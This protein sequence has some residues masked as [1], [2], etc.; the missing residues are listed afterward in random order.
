MSITLFFRPQKVTVVAE[1]EPEAVPHEK[2][3]FIIT[4]NRHQNPRHLKRAKGRRSSDCEQGTFGFICVG[5][6]LDNDWQIAFRVIGYSQIPSVFF[7][8]LKLDFLNPYNYK[9]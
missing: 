1:K 9:F 6:F 2:T 5:K 8:M 4:M 3:E 7:L